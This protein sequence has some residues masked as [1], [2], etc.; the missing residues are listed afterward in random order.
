MTR[1]IRGVHRQRARDQALQQLAG[2]AA[3][4]SLAVLDEGQRWVLFA[5]VQVFGLLAPVP[6]LQRLVAYLLCHCGM[7]LR[8]GLIAQL[9]DSSPQTLSR[10]RN[11][12]P[13]ELLAELRAQRSGPAKLRPEHVGPIARFLVEHPGVPAGALRKFIHD[14]LGVSIQR[15]TLARFLRRYGLGCLRQDRVQPAPLFWAPP[16]LAAPSC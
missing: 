10:L 15:H 8:L 14:E 4:E 5:F 2:G 9:L 16:A 6:R 1:A 12:T 13:E 11:Q 3:A 7:D